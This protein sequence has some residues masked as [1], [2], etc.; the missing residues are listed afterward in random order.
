MIYH[1]TSA[2]KGIITFLVALLLFNDTAIASQKGEKQVWEGNYTYTDGHPTN[3]TIQ[4]V[5]D[6]SGKI[7]DTFVEKIH[8]KNRE[9]E[10]LESGL[11]GEVTGKEIDF[12]KQYRDAIG[13]SH[14]VRFVGK[15][16]FDKKTYVGTWSEDRVSGPF[17]MYLSRSETI[18]SPNVLRSP[19]VTQEKAKEKLPK[20]SKK[21]ADHSGERMWIRDIK[22]GC[23]I[24]DPQP[25]TNEV[26]T[27]SGAC[28]GGEAS[29]FGEGNFI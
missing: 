23:W 19:A 1:G 15:R 16:L 3:F 28:H 27:W 13:G 20:A 9:T 10:T 7:S 29:G 8:S 4:I 17:R 24:F 26:V 22:T 6:V 25:A 14:K 12:T 5:I 11:E 2:L 18:S 21:L